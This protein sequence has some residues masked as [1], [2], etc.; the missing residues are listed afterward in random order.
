MA[1]GTIDRRAFLRQGTVT[2]AAGALAATHARV[3]AADDAPT[4]TPTGKKAR[5][6]V[7]GCGSVSTK[8]IPYLKQTR[9]VD[10]VAVCDRRFERAE[11]AAAD[12][13]VADAYP[14]ID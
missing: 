13:D 10:L 3:A 12:H 2:I 8:Y 14:H 11:R 9:H 7:I 4:P 1:D 5:V 6:A